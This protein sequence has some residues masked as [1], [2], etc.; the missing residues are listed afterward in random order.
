MYNGEEAA[1]TLIILE[2]NDD[3]HGIPSGLIAVIPKLSWGRGYDK[4]PFVYERD[5]KL[6]ADYLGYAE[7]IEV[8]G[9]KNLGPDARLK[10]W[11]EQIFA[12]KWTP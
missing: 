8:L 9:S 3:H 10:T 1:E 12:P 2:D 4:H 11:C 6:P 5:Y 7:S